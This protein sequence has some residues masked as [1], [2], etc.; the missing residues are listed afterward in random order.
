MGG[1]FPVLAENFELAGKLFHGLQDIPKRVLG[2]S[3]GAF[4]V[5][6][7]SVAQSMSPTAQKK[8]A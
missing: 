6:L 4:G 7:T 5:L 3:V 8:N 2:V 1:N